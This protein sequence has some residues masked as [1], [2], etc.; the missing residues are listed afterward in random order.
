MDQQVVPISPSFSA[1]SEDTG[2]TCPVVDL[3]HSDPAIQ[4]GAA[5][6]AHTLL[7][8]AADA[9]PGGLFPVQVPLQVAARSL[10]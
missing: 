1:C 8:R 4:P 9:P 3:C 7:W 2:D 10:W 5:G 6:L